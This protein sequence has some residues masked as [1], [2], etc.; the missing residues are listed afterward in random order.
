VL[1]ALRLL[2]P[3]DLPPIEALRRIAEWKKQL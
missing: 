1:H 2:N 3:N